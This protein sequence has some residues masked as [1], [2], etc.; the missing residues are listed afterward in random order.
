[1]SQY[2]QSWVIRTPEVLANCI[3]GIQTAVEEHDFY[4]R[5]TIDRYS[6][7]RTGAQNNTIHMW[8]SEIAEFTGEEPERIKEVLKDEYYPKEEVLVVGKL[9]VLPKSTSHLTLNECMVV[10][11]RIEAFCAEFDIPITIPDPELRYGGQT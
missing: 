11:E 10:M 3:S 1:M 6:K 8:F 9:K 5:V 2:K 4:W 7:P